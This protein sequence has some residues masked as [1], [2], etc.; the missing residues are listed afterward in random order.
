ML[1]SNWH[2]AMEAAD[3]VLTVDKN[4]YKAIL[5][6]AEALF[7]LCQFEHAL[8]IFVRG[9]VS[10]LPLEKRQDKVTSGGRFLN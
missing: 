5:I 3:K 9:Q 10:S 1:C 8:V 7:N 6:K 2:E 4:N